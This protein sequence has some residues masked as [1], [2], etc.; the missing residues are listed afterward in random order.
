MKLPGRDPQAALAFRPPRFPT[1][2]AYQYQWNDAIEVWSAKPEL[3]PDPPHANRPTGWARF[4]HDRPKR[5]YVAA[6]VDL[7]VLIPSPLR[8]ATNQ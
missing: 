6:Q 7:R 2:L 4:Q 8:Y 3:L 1:V 5:V